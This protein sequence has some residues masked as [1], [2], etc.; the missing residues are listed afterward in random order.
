MIIWKTRIIR[1]EDALKWGWW[2]EDD[3][4]IMICVLGV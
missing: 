4:S 3:Y 1:R 2:E